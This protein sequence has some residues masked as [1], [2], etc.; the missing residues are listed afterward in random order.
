[1]KKQ[2]AFLWMFLFCLLA[3]AQG[4]K[5]VLCDSYDDYGIPTGVHTNW[6]ID[7]AGGYVYVLYSQDYDIRQ[8][9]SLYVD[10]KKED[11]TYAA[12]DTRYFSFD[13]TNT[14][15]F[16]VYDFKFTKAGDFK[17]SV[18]GNGKALATTYC[19]VAVTETSANYLNKKKAQKNGDAVDTYYFEKSKITFG[20]AIDDKAVVTGEATVFYLRNGKRDIMAKLQQDNDLKVTQVL[21]EVYGGTDYK[22]KIAS[23]LYDIPSKTWNWMKVPLSFNKPGKYVVDMYNED[24]VFI[25]SGYLEIK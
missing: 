16:A 2:S 8:K 13:A 25:N 22:E 9:L 21:V 1:M 7:T 10:R 3:K 12:F 14:K 24:D 11:G 20:D 6:D 23:Q 19:N 4:E 17:I 5:V 15:K 18:M